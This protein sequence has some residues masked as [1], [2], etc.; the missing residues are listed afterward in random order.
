MAVQALFLIC[1]LA[2]RPANVG[3]PGGHD[4][5]D[6]REEFLRE[7][8]WLDELLRTK[9]PDHEFMIVPVKYEITP[10]GWIWVPFGWRGHL[11][12]RRPLKEA[13]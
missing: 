8:H 6:T 4:Y 9:Y 10:P 2:L 11:I 12:Y 13:A 3:N 5:P 1:A 7:W